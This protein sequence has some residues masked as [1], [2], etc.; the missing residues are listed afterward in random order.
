MCRVTHPAPPLKWL[1]AYRLLG[2]RLPERY[3]GWVADDVAASRFLT[4]RIARTALWAAVLFVL[5]AIGHHAGLGRW[6]A[7]ITFIRAGLIATAYA[8]FSSREVLVRR[9][10]QFQRIDKTGAPVARPKRFGLLH[11]A[12]AVL[13]AAVVAI[14]WTGMANVFGYGLRPSGIAAVPCREASPEVR[15]RIKAAFVKK[16]IE[17]LVT[18]SVPYTDAEMVVAI[19]KAPGREKDQA[20][21]GWI[22][23]PAGINRLSGGDPVTTFPVAERADRLAAQALERAVKCLE[24]KPK[25]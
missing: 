2:V 23:T 18:R 14:A 21:E 22:I 24:E 8:L 3:R 20:F 15:D 13:L 7:R 4:L 10:L 17:F 9:A 12:E 19:L 6:P 1:L 16:D 25:A 5:Y 11:S